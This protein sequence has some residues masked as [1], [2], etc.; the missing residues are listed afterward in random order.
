MGPPAEDET[1]TKRLP[2]EAPPSSVAAIPPP[3][4]PI[5]LALPE[6]RSALIPIV[7]CSG[8]TV[9]VFPH[10]L[11]PP[12]DS[13]TIVVKASCDIVPDA[14]A[15]L[16][17]QCDCL[18][19]D[20]YADQAEQASLRYPSD[21]VP[22]KPRADVVLWGN[23]HPPRG[24]ARQ[25]VVRFTF[26]HRGNRFT[27]QIAVFGDRHWQAQL[28]ASE[29]ER[30]KKVALRYEN[31]FGGPGFA[32]NPVGVGYRAKAAADG[33]ARLPA[34]E[35]PARLLQS[36]SDHP[37]PACFAPVPMTWQQ[38]WSKLGTF[39][40]RWREQRWP[41]FPEDFD[42]EFFQSAP[43]WQQLDFLRGDEP[44]EIDGAHRDHRK[45][46]GTL[47]GFRPRC[48]A[49]QTVQAGDSMREIALR[50]DTVAFDLENDEL[51]LLWRG[52][53]EVSGPSA[54]EIALLFATRQ[55]L[56]ADPVPL[57]Q[58][59]EQ[60]RAALLELEPVP[61]DPDIDTVA[62]ND[63]A[64][65][66]EGVLAREQ[67]SCSQPTP[68]SA[69]DDQP[70]SAE[71]PA[72]QPAEEDEQDEVDI[73]TGLKEAFPEF[74]AAFDEPPRAVAAPGAPLKVADVVLGAPTGAEPDLLMASLREAGLDQEQAA[75]LLAAADE[76]SDD[77]ETLDDDELQ[78]EA[79]D[80]PSERAQMLREQVVAR[81][82]GGQSLAGLDL[83]G[84]D[85]SELDLAGQSLAGVN[86]QAAQL[87][88][89]VLDGADLTDAQLADCDLTE[90]SLKGAKLERADLCRAQLGGA[91]FDHCQLSD[92]DFSET[93]APGSSFCG[94]AGERSRFTDGQ[95]PGAQFVRAVLPAVDFCRAQLDKAVFEEAQ[96][97]KLRLHGTRGE[98]ISFE[99]A[100][101]SDARG[102]EARLIR[103]S[104]EQTR[105]AGSVWENAQLDGSSFRG[106]FFPQASF[107]RASCKKTIFSSADITAGRLDGARLK[108]VSMLKAN[109]MKA[110]FE[111]AD[112]RNA[113]LR[114]ANLYGAAAWRAQVDG[115]AF[116]MAILT[117]S[118]FEGLS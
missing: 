69:D 90:A 75:M 74:A 71:T 81:L 12:R 93:H 114:G 2:S 61:F 94:A 31:A 27:R 57:E 62:A 51:H 53:I 28:V 13:F 117:K 45:L 37:E 116:E 1:V 85:L 82:D 59:E 18:C 96:L 106:A 46:L 110:S 77:D 39:D 14:P 32:A 15:R 52:V 103:C 33:R 8:L 22:F 95:L 100:D 44:F 3:P 72:Q 60:M 102:D 23:A 29:P 76:S 98:Q 50:L 34:L 66:S 43:S 47:P 54:P 101:L 36:P 97:A 48:F 9:A 65:L 87:Q 49:Q 84:A 92:A 7:D 118:G 42:W 56:D 108:G 109:L 91:V 73:I 41:F 68:E 10:Q 112:L 99:R 16:R 26:G 105:G 17:D 4:E 63:P 111:G 88:R 80:S 107:V 40:R 11:R 5:E 21:L 25:S 104:F 86:L 113:D 6:R 38:R 78:D 70:Y 67:V 115:A 79:D 24:S 55:L 89:A 35:D 30:F 19:G 64:E 58:I 83:H 20:R